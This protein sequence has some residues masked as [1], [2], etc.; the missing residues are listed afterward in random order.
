[1]RKAALAPIAAAL[2]ACSPRAVRYVAPDLPSRLPASVAVLPFDNESVSLKGPELARRL[3]AEA[4]AARGF[5]SP[6]A[7]DVDEALTRL[8]VSDGGQLRAFDPKKVGEAVGAAGLLYGTLEEFTYQN[9]GFL[10]RRA[11]RLTLKLVEAATGERLYEA[12]GAESRGRAALDKKAA[13]R[14]FV[15]GV[16]E[17][18]VET[19]LGAPLLL[20]SRLAVDEA[21]T[22]LPRR[23]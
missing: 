18:A 4:L 15:D 20:E 2:A 13:G 6:E 16:V 14:N 17:Q 10:R 12:V 8:G 11:V 21:L 1:M 5:S 9:V 22:G 19:A 3:T 23:P 7:K